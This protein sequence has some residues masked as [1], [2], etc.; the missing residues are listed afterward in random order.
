[1]QSS[2]WGFFN[3]GF[4]EGFI[5][6]VSAEIIFEFF[7]FS[8]NSILKL[9]FFLLTTHRNVSHTGKNTFVW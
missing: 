7:V 9:I 3:F 4:L 8:L 2:T 1:M 6:E 5:I